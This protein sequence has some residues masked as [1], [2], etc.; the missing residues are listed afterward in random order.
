MRATEVRKR[1]IEYF[2]KQQHEHIASSRLVPD[3]DPTLLFTNS[4]MVQFKNALLGHET[5][6]YK[7]A[8]TSQ[9]CV[10]AGGKHN[11]LENVGHTARHHT[12][13]EMLGN[14]SFGD[15][16]KKEAIHFAWDFITND[17]KISKDKLYVTVFTN[18]DE[19]HEIW[20]KQ[21]KVPT[22][23]IS[24]FGEKDNFWQMGDTGPCGPC[25]EIFYD[26]GAKYGCGKPDCK[27]GCPCDR[28]VEIWNLVFMQF[29][30][31]AQ[32]NLTPLPK[33]SIDTGAGLERMTAV[34]QQVASNYDTDL[35]SDLFKV[36]EKYFNQKYTKSD[37]EVGVA[38]RVLADHSRATAFL[39]ADGVLPSNEGQGYVLR[40]IMRRGIR[41]GR[42]LTDQSL[43]VPTVKE[44]I[45]LMSDTYPELRMRE[46]I[47]ISTIQTEEERFITTLDQGTLLLNDVL[48]DLKNKKIKTV[49]GDVVFKLYDTYGFPLDLTTVMA[50]EAG[51]DIDVID[52]E[53]RMDQQR[54]QAKASWKGGSTD[55]IQSLLVPAAGKLKPTEFSGYESNDDSS[56]VVALFSETAQVKELKGS[57][58]LVVIKTPFYGESGGQV[59]DHGIFKTSN[60]EGKILDTKRINDIY[61]HFIEVTKG[62][63]KTG[64]KISLHVDISRKATMSNH[65]ATHLMHAALRKVLGAH[66]TQAGSRVEALRLRFDFTH[67]KPMTPDEIDQV[68]VLV[69]KEI[70]AHKIVGSKVLPYNEAVKGGAMALFGEKY[71]DVVRVISMGDFSQELCGGT[72]V[73]NTGDI[74]VFKILSEGG[75]S[76]GVRRIEAITGDRAVAYLFK[77]HEELSQIEENLKAEEGKALERVKKLS[78]TQKKL[79]RDL[80]N[81]L[82]QGQSTNVDELVSSSKN[83]KGAKIISA[84]VQVADRDL[85][86]ALCDRIKDKLQSGVIVLIGQSSEGPSP[87]VVS[88]TKDLVGKFHA[89]NILKNVAA[90]MDGKGGGRPD[91]A[92]GAG[93][94]SAKAQDAAEKA[95]EL[96]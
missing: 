34:M 55:M 46:K 82:V 47:I 69:N 50:Q 12:F 38:M 67:T 52:F 74:R 72:H 93:P 77:R 45:N 19:A 2:K 21:E 25:S 56:E 68:E 5:K 8:T 95:Y 53:K 83:I 37:S 20:S 48:S 4:G 26:H 17:L 84:C 11:D 60:S 75:V 33:P 62:S 3:N 31:D 51:F 43:I 54:T 81:A 6:P 59:G 30:K 94:N 28:F 90:L 36:M 92:Q 7:R 22:D 24:R 91:F 39:I 18:D 58:S 73:S 80:K 79:E 27:V 40:R 29:N 16:F 42:K 78:E 76:S 89:G 65:S 49:G 63:L 35:F 66:V 15:Y 44:V 10:R 70:S 85:L 9:K 23:R 86:S 64:D 71:A 13:F 14:F 87:I 96:V 88:V 61:F 32:G 57:G 1:F 41:Y